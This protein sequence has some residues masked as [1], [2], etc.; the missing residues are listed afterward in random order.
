M[1]ISTSEPYT[2]YTCHKYYELPEGTK[3]MIRDQIDS[4]IIQLLN[5]TQT[6]APLHICETQ[7][8]M[9]ID[10]ERGVLQCR[11]GDE[12]QDQTYESLRRDNPGEQCNYVSYTDPSDYTKPIKNTDLSQCGFNK[13]GYAWCKLRDGDRIMMEGVRQ[14][15]DVMDT[16]DKSCHKRTGLNLCASANRRAKTKE[17]RRLSKF[18]IYRA[19][20]F[21]NVANNDKCVAGSITRL[22]WRGNFED[23]TSD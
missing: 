4:S 21:A 10:R 3:F 19:F 12:S 20:P 7:N 17:G 18:G 16:G 14:L 13:D 23:N 2:N 6:V 8:G 5:L 22:F 15:A 1:C 9:M 11:R